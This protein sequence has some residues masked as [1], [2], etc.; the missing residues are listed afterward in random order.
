L[1][2]F[3]AYVDKNV[4]NGEKKDVAVTKKAVLETCVPDPDPEDL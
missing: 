2:N 1:C 4:N 3:K